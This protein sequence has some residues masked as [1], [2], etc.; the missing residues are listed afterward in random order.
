MTINT[1]FKFSTQ[2]SFIIISAY[3]AQ[4]IRNFVTDKTQTDLSLYEGIQIALTLI[5]NPHQFHNYFRYPT[6][7]YNTAPNRRGNL[8]T[9]QVRTVTYGLKSVYYGM[10]Y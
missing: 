1:T 6:N 9:P 8:N 3:A 7:N 4:R 10:I 2:V 5:L